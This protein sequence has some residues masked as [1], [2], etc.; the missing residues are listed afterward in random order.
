MKLFN[1][2]RGG[3]NKDAMRQTTSLTMAYLLEQNARFELFMRQKV[4]ELEAIVAQQ[5]ARQANETPVEAPEPEHWAEKETGAREME[6]VPAGPSELAPVKTRPAKPVTTYFSDFSLDDV[7]HP[8]EELVGV[9]GEIAAPTGELAG[10]AELPAEEAEGFGE[11]YLPSANLPPKPEVSAPTPD[12]QILLLGASPEVEP[13]SVEVQ[14]IEG[15]VEVAEALLVA[16][17]PED[18]TPVEA[19]SEGSIPIELGDLTGEPA[20]ENE[21]DGSP[22]LLPAW[23]RRQQ[24]QAMTKQ[25][26]VEP[27]AASAGGGVV[28][29]TPEQETAKLITPE[30]GSQ[31][32]A[33]ELLRTIGPG[34]NLSNREKLAT[35]PE[36]TGPSDDLA[37]GETWEAALNKQGP[38]GNWE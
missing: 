15:V 21:A 34:T 20:P 18:E 2:L 30:T 8:V 32:L 31:A 4:G 35:T 11:V 27:G 24:E 26:K 22:L 38:A 28:E 5:Q 25:A 7:S 10:A 29:P 19:M 9:G 12:W 23:L 1:A 3:S 17:A 37:E 33:G 6:S 36:I 16:P 13:I 14:E